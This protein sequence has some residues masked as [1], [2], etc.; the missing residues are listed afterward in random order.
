[1]FSGGIDENSAQEMSEITTALTVLNDAPATVLAVHHTGK[2]AGT[3][4][5]LVSTNPPLTVD[6]RDPGRRTPRDHPAL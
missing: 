4:H 1:M 3:G 5:E 2:S 6:P